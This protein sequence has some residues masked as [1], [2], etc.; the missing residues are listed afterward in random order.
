VSVDRPVHGQLDDGTAFFAPIGEIVADGSLVTCHL[1][2]RLFRSVT[3]HL[4]SHGWSKERYCL[5]FGL[6]RGQSLEGPETR[7]LRAAA[8]TGRLL[9]EPAVREGS[10]AGRARARSG[11]L[12]RDAATAARGRSFPEQRRR[13]IAV[14]RSGK[15]AAGPGS[16]QRAA[17][18]L[19]SVADTAARRR[20]YPDFPAF[21]RARAATGASLAAISR[22]AGLHKDWLSRHLAKIDPATA[23]AVRLSAQK[24]PDA[25]WMSALRT[26]GQPDVASYLRLRHL[27]QHKTVTAIA[28]EVGLSRHAVESALRRHGLTREAHAAARHAARRRAA[29]VAAALG[30]P[31]VAAY[32]DERRS[33]GCTWAVISGESGQPQGWLRRHA[34][35][36]DAPGQ[37][38]G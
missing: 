25:R 34:A 8:F 2:G 29:R 23:A 24:R 10:A 20:G 6:E 9:F 26:L 30:Y 36:Q 15:P 16:R 32:V 7:K 5:V 35:R 37:K 38:H 31:D 21:V 27:E 3:A 4:P 33:Q 14:A 17:V 12:A 1:C 19:A 28:A 18:Y 22:E 13:K 11:A